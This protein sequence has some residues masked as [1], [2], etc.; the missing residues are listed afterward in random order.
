MAARIF[1]HFCRAGNFEAVCGTAG[2]YVK[3]PFLDVC[4]VYIHHFKVL[5]HYQV[6]VWPQRDFS[7]YVPGVVYDGVCNQCQAVYGVITGGVKYRIVGLVDENG[8]RKYLTK[9]KSWV[10]A[11]AQ[12]DG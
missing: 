3:R 12:C 5:N 9:F 8:E 2:T 4:A 6:G 10:R 11:T 7:R 1:E